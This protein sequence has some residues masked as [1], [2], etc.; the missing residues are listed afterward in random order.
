[1]L[2]ERSFEVILGGLC[3]ENI[4]SGLRDKLKSDISLEDKEVMRHAAKV[5]AEEKEMKLKLF[6]KAM[7]AEAE[8]VEVNQVGSEY[9]RDGGRGK[10][11]HFEDKQVGAKKKLNPFA[12]IEELRSQLRNN[13]DKVNCTT[14]RD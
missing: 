10:N 5:I 6:G 13:D 2:A 7:E 14:E 11:V 9:A 1:M 8:D 3:D 12:E 4:R